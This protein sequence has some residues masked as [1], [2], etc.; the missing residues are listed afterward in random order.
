MGLCIS[1]KLCPCQ[2]AVDRL[3]HGRDNCIR[4]LSATVQRKNPAHTCCFDVEQASLLPAV[5][6][7]WLR[8]LIVHSHIAF[9]CL[10]AVSIVV[11]IRNRIP[12]PAFVAI[13]LKVMKYRAVYGRGSMLQSP[14]KTISSTSRPKTATITVH[15]ASNCRPVFLPEYLAKISS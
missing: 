7:L 14:E 10:S 8:L 12:F 5:S 2:P 1:R 4:L 11:M 3:E 6:L 9:S 13:E 15:I